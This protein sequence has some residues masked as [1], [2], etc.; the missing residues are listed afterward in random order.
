M[1]WK[2]LIKSVS[3][4]NSVILQIYKQL[5]VFV[6]YTDK[7]LY[8]KHIS[9]IAIFAG[10][11]F[12]RPVLSIAQIV[13]AV[14]VVLGGNLKMNYIK[15]RNDKFVFSFILIYLIHIIGLIYSADL[16][17]AAQDLQIKL[18]LVLF[19]MAFLLYYKPDLKLFKFIQ[20]VLLVLLTLKLFVVLGAYFHNYQTFKLYSDKIIWHISHIRL[21]ILVAMLFF[22]IYTKIVIYKSLNWYDVYS[23]ILIVIFLLILKS[24][25]GYLLFLVITLAFTIYIFKL[26]TRI[27]YKILFLIII[28]TAAFFPTYSLVLLYKSFIPKQI[29]DYKSLPSVTENN[30]PYLHDTINFSFENGYHTGLFLCEAE[31]EKQ[32]N[33]SSKIAYTAFDSK[34]QGIRYTIIR[35][36]TSKNLTKDSLGFSHLSAKDIKNIENGYTNYR[37]T[38]QAGIST[39][40][41]ELFCELQNYNKGYSTAGHS[42]TQRL[43]FTKIA[44]QIIKNNPAFGVGTGDVLLAFEQIYKT[45]NFLPSNKWWLRSHNQLLTFLIA[46]GIP[47]GLVSVFLLYAPLLKLIN[48]PHIFWPFTLLAILIMLNEDTLETQH[49]VAVFGFFYCFIIWSV[50]LKQN[51]DFNQNL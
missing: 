24:I 20:I 34:N 50:S 40:V 12:S 16:N 45:N 43:E 10:I 38:G 11:L 47:L 15:L 19:P 39:R 6:S 29:P 21:S 44:L 9:I 49:G 31:L 17:R 37:F 30:T 3:K 28:I 13:L 32:W 41:Y 25:T 27:K 26:I 36:L 7:R 48:E 18:P 23:V 14:V 35:Y 5:N 2:G 22:I 51:P 1:I 42:I 33:S 46:F 8:I 4:V